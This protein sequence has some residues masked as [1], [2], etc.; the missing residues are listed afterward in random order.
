MGA[1]ANPAYESIRGC[2]AEDADH[3]YEDG[4]EALGGCWF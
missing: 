4:A 1:L 3:G 2:G